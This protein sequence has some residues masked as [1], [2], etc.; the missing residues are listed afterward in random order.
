MVLSIELMLI[1]SVMTAIFGIP[2]IR[3]IY[4]NYVKLAVKVAGERIEVV[5]QRL[6]ER[7]SDVGK[8]VNE[9]MRT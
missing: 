4:R 1:I 6:S 9:A 8:K 3:W 2:I 5:Q 7:I